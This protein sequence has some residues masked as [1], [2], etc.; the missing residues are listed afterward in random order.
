LPLHGLRITA[1]RCIEAAELAL[2]PRRNY[3]YGANGA[4]K[5]SVLE[6]IFLLGR[7][8]SFRTRSTAT[9]VRH[10]QEAL[11]V[12][13][14]IDDGA[15]MRRLGA[16]FSGRHLDRRLDGERATGS[17]VAETLPVH[18][19]GPDSHD[20]VQGG[21]IGRRRLID[22]GVFH[23]ERAYLETWRRYRRS[24]SQRNTA[25]KNGGTGARQLGVWT[26]A[27]TEAGEEID[28][29]RTDYVGRLAASAAEHARALL[30]ADI[31]VDY[32]RG[33]PPGVALADALAASEARDRLSG[34]TEVGP[35]RAD[36]T[37]HV[38]GHEVRNVASRGQQKLV[39]AAL[40]LAQETVLA[41]ARG[42]RGV[43]LVDDPAAE[44]DSGAVDR[45]LDRLAQVQSQ[46][47]FTGLTPRELPA[48]LS[49]ALFHVERGRVA[50]L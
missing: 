2:H 18:A 36:V 40:I 29:L 37:L 33:W 12:Y 16:T 27:L 13:G 44:L 48:R 10:G 14:D 7:G 1:F 26:T 9:L 8:R 38:D 49:S 23:V 4:G 28:R 11:T 20:L 50:A 5:S 24:L 25:L 43:L 47:I 17:A 31:A 42:A 32:R 3:I 39:V 22:W 45:L 46:L 34:H 30:G 21:P 41:G 6:A 35:H 19:I 15:R